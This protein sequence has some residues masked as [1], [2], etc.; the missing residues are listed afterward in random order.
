MANGQYVI[1]EAE[2]TPQPDVLISAP[3][4]QPTPYGFIKAIEG[5]LDSYRETA[6]AIEDTKRPWLRSM[7]SLV[8]TPKPPLAELIE[9]ESIIGGRLFQKQEETHDLRFWCEGREW[10]FGYNSGKDV[11][12]VDTTVHY[13]VSDDSIEK[14]YQGRVAPLTP[15]EHEHFVEAV[16]KYETAV[17]HELYPF[18]EVIQELS[19][20]D[21]RLAA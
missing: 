7:K 13:A 18:D 6:L 10:F 2:S 17:V 16:Q 21:F 11:S 9:K 12:I 5:R 19:K 8:L 15:G 14:L 1:P 20:D 3:E 4:L